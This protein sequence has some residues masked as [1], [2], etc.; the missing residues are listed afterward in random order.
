M[1]SYRIGIISANLD[2]D[3]IPFGEMRAFLTACECDFTDFKAMDRK[4]AYMRVEFKSAKFLYLHE[5]PE[6]GTVLEPL[7]QRYRQYLADKIK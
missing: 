2:W 4:D 7:V 1:S 3:D 6:W 5:S